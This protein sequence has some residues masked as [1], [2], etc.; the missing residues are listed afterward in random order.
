MESRPQ[1][2]AH[3]Q[4]TRRT[5]GVDSRYQPVS[6]RSV[7]TA[8]ATSATRASHGWSGAAVHANVGAV[9]EAGARAGQ[10]RDEIGQLLHAPD[11]PQRIGPHVGGELPFPLGQ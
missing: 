4:N 1:A 7:F 9:D 5:F 8:T 6:D 10:E 2:A 11:A 3:V